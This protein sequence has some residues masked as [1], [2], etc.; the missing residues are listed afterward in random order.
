LILAY[1]ALP[2]ATLVQ[3]L[4]ASSQCIL[5]SEKTAAR[6]TRFSWAWRRQWTLLLLLDAA[7]EWRP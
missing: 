2:I 4:W 1:L 7:F 3:D 6:R 5:P